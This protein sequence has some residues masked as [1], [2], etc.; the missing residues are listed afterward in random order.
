[1]LRCLLLVAL[2]SHLC[3]QGVQGVRL[4]NSMPHQAKSGPSL[5]L[6]QTRVHKKMQNKMKKQ[7]AQGEGAAAVAAKEEVTF[8]P[9][10]LAAA[11]VGEQI[12]FGLLDGEEVN[13]EITSVTAHGSDRFVWSGTVEGG[14]FYLSYAEGA[15]VG[16]VY[17][18]EQKLQY[19]YRPLDRAEGSY[20]LRQVL[21]SVYDEVPDEEHAHELHE[22]S[23]SGLVPGT[24]SLSLRRRGGDTPQVVQGLSDETAGTAGDASTDNAILDVMVLL[25]NEAYAHFGRDMAS[26][27]V[28]HK[29]HIYTCIFTIKPTYLLRRGHGLRAGERHLHT[30]ISAY[31]HTFHTFIP[32]YLL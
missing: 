31:L 20:S 14:S 2:L 22:L 6:L 23:K 4:I 12:S 3:V 29:T 17:Y 25:T 16:N 11:T 10:A 24:D 5:A 27:L 19:E 1:M 15:I 8:L 9:S 21:M 7:K 13:G 30:C 28:R 32:S 26:V 18:P